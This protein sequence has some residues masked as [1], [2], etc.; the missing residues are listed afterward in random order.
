MIHD[1][2]YPWIIYQVL[3]IRGLNRR[4]IDAAV[5]AAKR[6]YQQ[7]LEDDARLPPASWSEEDRRVA[8]LLEAIPA[9]V[10]FAGSRERIHSQP[11]VKELFLLGLKRSARYL[12][13]IQETLD[14]LGVPSQIA[15]LPLV[16]SSFCTTAKSKAGA[17]G[18]WQFT[19]R[20]G[21]RFLRIDRDLDE[22]RDPLAATRAAAEYLREA[23]HTLGSWPLAVTAYNHGVGGV[24]RASQEFGKDDLARL[25]EDYEGPYF[26]FASQNFYCEFLAAVAVAQSPEPYFGP[27]DADPPLLTG[28]LPLTQPA[29]LPALA[30]A[31]GMSVSDLAG[32]NPALGASYVE[33]RR[34]LPK[35]Y[36]LQVPSAH[37]EGTRA[38]YVAMAA[39][40][41]IAA[42]DARRATA[43]AR[44]T[45]ADADART[46][47]VSTGIGYKVRPGDT[48]WV[49]ARLHRIPVETLLRLNH[50]TRRTRIF[51]GENLNLPA[52]PIAG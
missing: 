14:S 33:G 42:A 45:A 40:P 23:Y 31:F 51:P 8:S 9:D 16:E 11:G 15:Y 24:F 12:P 41:R 3:D 43:G 10:R 25:L 4:Q 1:S 47:T 39:D 28:G 17:V 2:R 36:V 38:A 35:G 30:Q 52:G 20:T 32:L 18:I 44:T 21:R 13:A 34:A 50:L 29:R 6:R 19:G 49:I 46:E 37:A 22:R 27:I 5:D 48:V 26:G 7:I